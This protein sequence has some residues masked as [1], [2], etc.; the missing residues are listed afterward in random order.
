MTIHTLERRQRI[1]RPIGDV[2]AFFA[3]PLNLDRLTPPWLH[4]RMLTPSP[5]E[6][7][8]GLNIEYV[9]RWRGLPVRWCTEI[10]E[11]IPGRRFV[12]RQVRGPYRLW[13]HTHTFLENGGSTNMQDTVRYALPAGAL[14]AAVHGLIVRH[15]LE[16][17]FDFRA[18]RVRELI[19]TNS[20]PRSCRVTVSQGTFA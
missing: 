15:D 1:A 11:W 16:R 9:I 5:I 17:I 6:M 13:H 3:D 7:R 20:A 10:E 14:G 8:V 18:G 12:D 19:E 2:F 4:F